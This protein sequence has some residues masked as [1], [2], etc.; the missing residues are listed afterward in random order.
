M[1]FSVSKG[2]EA[3]WVILPG[4][5]VVPGRICSFLR[6][7]LRYFNAIALLAT[8]ITLSGYGLNIETAELRDHKPGRRSKGEMPS[9][10]VEVLGVAN[11]LVQETILSPLAG[12]ISMMDADQVEDMKAQD[13]PSALRRTPGMIVSRHNTV[14][15]F[16]GGEGGSVFIRG[17]GSSR[18]GAEI[19]I[20]MD[21]VPRVMGV[22]T[23]PLMDLLS[24]DVVDRIEIHK[25][26]QP[27][28][29]G[30]G[31]F[32]ALGITTKS[33]TQEGRVASM[34][35]AGG[36]FS[37]GVEVAEYGEK[38][39]AV[40]WYLVQSWRRSSGHREHSGGELKSLFGR[41]GVELGSRWKVSLTADGTDNWAEDP[42]P[43]D[44]SQPMQGR[45]GTHDAFG[46]L[47]LSHSHENA[48][49]YVKLYQDKSAI[50]WTGQY[51]AATRRNDSGTLT[52]SN[53][54]GL[55]MR[56]T[57][58]P[59]QGGEIILGMD[60]DF[61]GGKVRAIAPPA[62]DVIFPE[63]RYR[64][65]SPYASVSHVFDIPGDW[66]VTPSVG[67][68]VTD[69]SVFGSGVGSQAGL[70][71]MHEKTELFVN[72]ARGLNYPGLYAQVQ[73][74][75]WMPGDN[76]WK[77]LRPE[78]V[79]HQE[80]G[81][82]QRVS[83]TLRLEVSAFQDEGKDRIAVAPPP[84]FPPRWSNLGAWKIQGVE[85]TCTWTPSR[86]FAIFLGG[87]YLDHD[88]VDLP[89][90]PR[91]TA[92]LGGN[93]RFLERFML[94]VDG[95]FVDGHTVTSRGRQTTAVNLDK[96]GA[97]AVA[98]ARLSWDFPVSNALGQAFIAVENVVDRAYEQ[99]KAYPM[100]GR[101]FLAGLKVRL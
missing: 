68:R 86:D 53:N 67:L 82:R 62:P 87:T 15:S 85:S 89:Y 20:L 36:A 46:V 3:G 1:V 63:T 24:V 25:G 54:S 59:W 72:F 57:R 90:T 75:L 70:V 95:Q 37:T 52:D 74:A 65:L 101:S 16:G 21:G 84:P 22:W 34:E 30:A 6:Q 14:G 5:P 99:K 100:P 97:Y 8:G 39:G 18:P 49:G 64:Q 56:E 60:L 31:S 61:V 93:W 13:L 79:I 55:R 51:T 45:F 58:K 17:M 88:P 50:R 41:I 32:G 42:G 92:T 28:L 35:L 4:G 91:R 27:V 98:N 2:G 40:D 69:H 73:D 76:H 71:L 47:T 43:K 9:A 48:Q 11:P 96:V 19:Q 38:R 80:V 66:R 29:L 7:D 23:H 94:S 77:D 26:A 10:T 12:P 78:R 44:G 81:I 33:M 83:S